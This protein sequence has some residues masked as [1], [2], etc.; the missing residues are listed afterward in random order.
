M[1]MDDGSNGT[2]V[3]AKTKKIETGS[4]GVEWKW[5]GWPAHHQCATSRK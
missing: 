4:D 5:R 2:K 1:A 3:V